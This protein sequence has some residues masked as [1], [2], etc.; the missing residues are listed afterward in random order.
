M[1][2]EKLLDFPVLTGIVVGLFVGLHYPVHVDK[3]VLLV[4]AAVMGLKVVGVLK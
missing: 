3:T 1:K 4:I 2:I